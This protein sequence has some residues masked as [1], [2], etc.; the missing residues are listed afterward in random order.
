M[1]MAFVADN[2]NRTQ[3]ERLRRFGVAAA[4]VLSV[5]SVAAACNVP[6]FRYALERWKADPYQAV[7]GALAFI[8]VVVV[9]SFYYAKTNTFLYNLFLKIVDRI[10]S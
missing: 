7:L 1:V 10:K 8:L 5:V 9:I 2:L 4:V 3:L 6:V